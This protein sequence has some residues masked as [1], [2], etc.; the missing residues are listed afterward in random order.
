VAIAL[1]RKQAPTGVTGT[2]NNGFKDVPCILI[3]PIAVD[4][5]NLDSTVVADG[6]HARADVYASAAK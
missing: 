1:A 4:R 3:P 2:L 6:F 5:A